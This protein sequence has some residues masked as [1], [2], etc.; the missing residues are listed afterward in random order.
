VSVTFPEMSYL[1]S[2]CNPPSNLPISLVLTSVLG[3]EYAASPRKTTDTPY[4]SPIV[5]CLAGLT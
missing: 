5:P 1:N 3:F 2:A 4:V